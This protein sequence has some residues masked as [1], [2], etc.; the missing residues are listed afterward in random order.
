MNNLT[1]FNFISTWKGDKIKILKELE[2]PLGD[3][4]SFQHWKM[5][6]EIEISSLVNNILLVNLKQDFFQ[7]MAK[8]GIK[9]YILF[10]H[11]SYQ[12]TISVTKNA[13]CR[14][15]EAT[16]QQTGKSKDLSCGS[17]WKPMWCKRKCCNILSR[18]ELE[19]NSVIGERPTLIEQLK[20]CTLISGEVNQF[21]FW[22]QLKWRTLLP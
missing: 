5:L 6:K 10:C 20:C 19:K 21:K 9:S 15:C 14:E 17:I 13:D 8:Q 4:S 1:I 12:R 7:T 3:N 16:Q 18:L 11:F 22:S 2:V